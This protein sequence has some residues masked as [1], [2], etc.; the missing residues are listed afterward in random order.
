MPEQQSNKK[1]AIIGSGITGVGAAWSL[2]NTQGF[3]VTLYEAADRLGGHTNTIQFKNPAEFDGSIP[4]DTGFIVFNKRTYPNFVRFLEKLAVSYKGSDMSF[5]VSRRF[6]DQ[7]NTRASGGFLST[8]NPLNVLSRL[9]FGMQRDL[10]WSGGGLWTVFAQTSNLLNLSHYLMVFD[11]FRFSYCAPQ[12]LKSPQMK[13]WSIGKYLEHYGF[14]QYFIDNYLIPMTASIWS[15]DA[16]ACFAQFPAVTLI[17]FMLNHG[18]LSILEERPV[19]YTV[20]NGSCSYIQPALKRVK[21]IKTGSAVVEVSYDSS[22]ARNTVRDAKGDAQEFDYVLFACHGDQALKLLKDP[23]VN[24][25]KVLSKVKYSPNVAYVHSDL[26]LMPRLRSTWS[27]WNYICQDQSES[28]KVDLNGSSQVKLEQQKNGSVCLTYWMNLLQSIDE[29]KYGQVLV[30]LNP[31]KEPS[32][33]IQ[34][35]EYRHP[36]YNKDLVDAQEELRCINQDAVHPG[37]NR[38]LFGGAWAGY[39]FHED[40]LFSGLSMAALVGAKSS[41][42][43]YDA[44]HLHEV[45][46]K[47]AQYGQTDSFQMDSPMEID[48][49]LNNHDAQLDNIAKSKR[50]GLSY[51]AELYTLVILTWLNFWIG[52]CSRIL[53]TLH[54][55]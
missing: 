54:L 38:R 10:E 48:D 14:S 34:K 55:Y 42:G 41:I 33:T 16:D 37:G 22:T 23:S 51:I 28:G 11:I 4:V 49:I 47:S 46:I 15:T 27:A 53:K 43:V 50:T 32:N 36:L 9:V 13:D 18:L 7:L 5:A 26:S 17:R 40:G 6:S 35:I 39:G 45:G 2:S 19:W 31:I 1:V 24:E 12:L 30:T 52:L 21:S 8:F 25:K 20:D 3:E 29:Q 44:S